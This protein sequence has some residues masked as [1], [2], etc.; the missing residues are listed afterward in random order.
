MRHI[1]H[2]VLVIAIALPFVPAARAQSLGDVAR[3]KRQKQQSKDTAKRKVITEDDLPKHSEKASE[4]PPKSE[5]EPESPEPPRLEAGDA[6]YAE[7]MKAAIRA[8][9]DVIAGL[10]DSIA[11]EEASIHFVEANHYVNGVQYN[12]AQKRK[13]EDVDRMKQQLAEQQSRLEEMQEA[14]RKAGFGNSVYDP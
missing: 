5:S 9:K 14:A 12:E 13:V 4:A 7:H 6:A 10:K 8:Q 1:A 11:K 2:F 3:E